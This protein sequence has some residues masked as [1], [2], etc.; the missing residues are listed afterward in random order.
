M[1][2][3]RD[4]L[5]K[6]RERYSF[7]NAKVFREEEHPRADDGKFGKGSG[8]EKKDREKKEKKQVLEELIDLPTAPDAAQ[9]PDG[10]K[11]EWNPDDGGLLFHGTN[12]PVDIEYLEKGSEGVVFLT[13][14]F[15]EAERY[16]EGVHLGGS[17]AKDTPRVLYI[18]TIGGKTLN[19][20]AEIN[21]LV[22]DGEDD[23]SPVFDMARKQ[24]ADYVYFSHPSNYSGDRQQNIVVALNP[25]DT[26]GPARSGW[27][28][29]KKTRFRKKNSNAIK[30]YRAPR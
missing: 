5:E 18:D 7:K 1:I 25:G 12:A 24:G 16:A 29:E 11:A 3:E 19:V 9:S 15:K 21:K 14:D 27:D 22:E 23:F 30:V 8:G 10:T 6:G 4:R 28:L 26:L 20:D 17:E 13:D 2:F